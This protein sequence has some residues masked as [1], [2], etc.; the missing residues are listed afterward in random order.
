MMWLDYAIHKAGDNFK[1]EGDWTGEVMG[2]DKDG[3]DKENW[4][5]KPGDIYRVAEDGWLVKIGEDK[6]DTK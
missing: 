6:D 5:Y 4:I 2:K 3:T 1:V